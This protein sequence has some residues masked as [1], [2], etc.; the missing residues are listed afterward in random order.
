MSR[1]NGVNSL[2]KVVEQVFAGIVFISMVAFVVGGT[3]AMCLPSATF[4]A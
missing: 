2:R 3:I 1:Q 4:S